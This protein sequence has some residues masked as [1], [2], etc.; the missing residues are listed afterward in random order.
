MDGHTTPRPPSLGWCKWSRSLKRP[1]RLDCGGPP[2]RQGLGE[3][4][5]FVNFHLLIIVPLL[6]AFP[7]LT[8]RQCI[9]YRFKRYVPLFSPAFLY[10]FLVLY[11]I[12]LLI[13]L[14]FIV[15][16]FCRFLFLTPDTPACIIIHA[17]THTH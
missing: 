3:L 16:N 15:L 7:T 4:L 10:L 5:G 2:P 6:L 11:S 14:Y 13:D 12:Y 9:V 1:L 8:I 17:Y